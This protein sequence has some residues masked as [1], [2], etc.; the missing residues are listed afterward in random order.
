MLCGKINKNSTV[1]KI[2]DSRG[3]NGWLYYGYRKTT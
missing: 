3:F 2:M 1:A